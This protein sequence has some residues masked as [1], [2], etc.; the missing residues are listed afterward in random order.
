MEWDASTHAMVQLKCTR[1]V[2]H[3]LRFM[4]VAL[5][6]TSPKD[7]VNQTAAQEFPAGRAATYLAL[8]WAGLLLT[9]NSTAASIKDYQGTGVRAASARARREADRI[10]GLAGRRRA[11]EKPILAKGLR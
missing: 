2:S 11:K 8:A 7:V 9:L 4:R 1:I 5:N 3:S 10:R 6:V